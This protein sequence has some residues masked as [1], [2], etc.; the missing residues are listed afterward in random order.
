MYRGAVTGGK[1]R[2]I[3]RA[4]RWEGAP[5]EKRDFYRGGK[6]EPCISA[7]T[8][9]RSGQFSRHNSDAGRDSGLY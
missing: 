7:W 4:R 5:E 3:L 8:G 2:T 6:L 9:L 1:V